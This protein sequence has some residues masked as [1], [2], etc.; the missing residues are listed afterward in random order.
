MDADVDRNRIKELEGRLLIN[1]LEKDA[2][3]KQTGAD[4]DGAGRN[5]RAM[6]MLRPDFFLQWGI[7]K[8]LK[9]VRVR[10]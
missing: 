9:C 8:R 2:S 5:K 1:R 3:K 10:K 7:R 6:K 4:M